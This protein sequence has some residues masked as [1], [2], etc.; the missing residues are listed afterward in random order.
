M[1]AVQII[2]IVLTWLQ[3]IVL[4]SVLMSW[5]DPDPYNKIVVTIRAITEPMYKPFRKLLGNLN[6]GPIDIAPMAV[7]MVLVFLQKV[8]ARVMMYL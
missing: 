8:L 7:L 3:Y 6:L 2:L 4:A 1:P 5:L